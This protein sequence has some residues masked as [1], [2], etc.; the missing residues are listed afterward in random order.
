MLHLSRRLFRA[1][2]I[3]TV[4]LHWRSFWPG[5]DQEPHGAA[6]GKYVHFFGVVP[7][8]GVALEWWDF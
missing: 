5:F 1:G 8:C 7:E 4:R 6:L 2:Y 3:F